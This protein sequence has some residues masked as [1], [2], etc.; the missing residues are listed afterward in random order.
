MGGVIA[1]EMARQLQGQGQQVAMLA[2]IDTRVPDTE[3][4]EFSSGVLLSIFAFDLGLNHE[5]LSTTIEETTSRQHMT[6]LRQVWMDARRAGLVPANMTLIEFRKL[7]DTFKQY[8][9]TMRRY[10]PGQFAG[11]ITLFSAEQDHDQ[12]PSKPPRPFKGWD[13]FVTGGVDIHAVPGD[14]FS[15]VREPHV[16]V[17]AERLRN[18]ID[19]TLR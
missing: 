19:D 15:M 1:F 12:P 7:F 2:L 8:A 5:N 3:G 9:N 11:R 10:R 13:A 16:R 6:R 17:L 14:H 4:T 18:C